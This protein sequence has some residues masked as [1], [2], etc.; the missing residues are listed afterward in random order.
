MRLFKFYP[1]KFS[2][3]YVIASDETEVIARK[4]ELFDSFM[5]SYWGED[6]VE[7]HDAD[8]IADCLSMFEEGLSNIE[9]HE[10]HMVD[11]HY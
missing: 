8:E 2:R 11:N 3:M 10:S 4:H 9:G 7:F 5:K 1:R 6:Y